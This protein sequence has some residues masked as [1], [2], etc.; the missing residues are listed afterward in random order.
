MYYSNFSCLLLIP[1]PAIDR[2][3][4]K[5]KAEGEVSDIQGFVSSLNIHS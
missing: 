1:P 2:E 4:L 3:A 5:M